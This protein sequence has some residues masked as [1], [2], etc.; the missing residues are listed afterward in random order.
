MVNN[1]GGIGKG[2]IAELARNRRTAKKNPLKIKK[3]HFTSP[4][5][6]LELHSSLWLADRATR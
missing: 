6:M 1:W 4:L 2:M 3:N 5:S